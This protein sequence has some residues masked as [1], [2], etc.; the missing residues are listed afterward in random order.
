MPDLTTTLAAADA[1]LNELW[2]SLLGGQQSVLAETGACC[3]CLPTHAEPPHHTQLADASSAVDAANLDR[4]P[5][6]STGPR[7]V[8]NWR[9]VLPAAALTRMAQPLPA[10]FSVHSVQT[11]EGCGFEVWLELQHDD[12]QWSRCRQWHEDGTLR[13]TDWESSSGGRVARAK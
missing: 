5:T 12:A 9:R 13:D 8:Q 11:T 7:N 10:R 1:A 4:R 6:D 3:Q 2:L